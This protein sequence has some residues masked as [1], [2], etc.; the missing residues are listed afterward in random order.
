MICNS[1]MDLT[2]YQWIHGIF[3]VIFVIISI[4]IG[5]RILSK[6]FTAEGQ[7]FSEYIPL[8]LT[9]I[10]LSSAWWGPTFNFL[11]FVSTE[12]PLNEIV[13]VILNNAFLPLAIVCW[14]YAYT[15]LQDISRKK[16]IR[17]IYLVISVIWEIVFFILIFVSL[18]TLYTFEFTEAGI[19]YSKRTL[20][21]LVFPIIALATA[22]LT[23]IHFGLSGLKSQ[24]KTIKWKGIFLMLAFILFVGVALLDALL[25]REVLWLVI[26]RLI[27]IFSGFCYYLGFFMPEKIK[28]ILIR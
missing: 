27:L 15:S 6:Y 19:Y 11:V 8:G 17:I 23:G 21:A 16:I 2:L 7:K 25:P 3:T 10:L 22:L 4:L 20:S 18:D 9:Y 1:V 24:D 26:L 13:F 28:N 12:T 5:L 14:I